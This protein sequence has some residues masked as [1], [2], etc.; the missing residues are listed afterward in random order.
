MYKIRTRGYS[1]EDPVK[2]WNLPDRVFF[3]CGACH[4]L[5]WAFLQR[6][7]TA[8]MKIEWIK[9]DPGFTGNH[10]FVT[11]GE[12]VFDYHGVSDREQFLEHTYKRARQW[13]PGWQ[14]GIIE[15][16]K[17]VLVSEKLS[18]SHDGLWLREPGQYLHNALPRAHDFLD[19]LLPAD[20]CDVVPRSI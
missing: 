8:G 14:A 9:P 3:A 16:P 10:V 12:R 18:R 11:L 5:A 17:Q 20:H 4:I 6:Y 7:E 1:K 2:R 15:L 19:R 13:W